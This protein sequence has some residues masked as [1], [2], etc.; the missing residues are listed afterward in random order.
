MPIEY[1][2]ISVLLAGI[3]IGVI[4]T[5]LIVRSRSS[6]LIEQGK[7]DAKAELAL[8]NE[9]LQERNK[10]I[11]NDN[12]LSEENKQKVS[13]LENER[14][15]LGKEL[16]TAIQ[17]NE[18]ILILEKRIKTKEEALEELRH[19][20]S[21]QKAAI[22]ELNTRNEEE[23]S[24]LEEQRTTLLQ[25]K[26][27]LSDQFKTLAQEIFEEKG[28][29]FTEQNQTK[30][31]TILNPFR[32]QLK[33]FKKKVDDVY[34]NEVKERASLKQELENLQKLNKQISQEATNLTKALKGDVK[35]QGNWGEL[36]LERVLEQ[37][38]LRKGVEYETQ[39]G[40]RDGD[41]HLLKP[42]VVIHMPEEKDFVVDSKV[43][44]ID[45]EK[46]SSSTDE[47][48]R[49]EALKAHILSIRK[50]INGLSGKDYS[51]LKGI[52]SLDFVLMFIP[53]EAA[54]MV[55]FQHDEKLFSDAFNKRI[56]VVT[57][58]T[59]LATLKTIENIWRYERQSQN[60]QSIVEKASS[61]YDKLRGFVSDMEK[62]GKQLSTSNRTYDDAMGK[63][64]RGK[65][66]LISQAQQ[67]VDMGVKVKKEISKSITAVSDLSPDDEKE[68]L[69]QAKKNEEPSSTAVVPI[70]DQEN[71]QNI[72]NEKEIIGD[73]KSTNNNHVN[74]T[75]LEDAEELD[76]M[77][78]TGQAK[79]SQSLNNSHEFSNVNIQFEIT[80]P[81]AF[82]KW[83]GFSL[84]SEDRKNFPEQEGA[85]NSFLLDFENYGE[86]TAWLSQGR[87]KISSKHFREIIRRNEFSSDDAFLVE[88]VQPNR[89]YKAIKKVF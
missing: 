75:L 82:I 89:R 40:F 2:L 69:H 48:V 12:Q 6:N 24:K 73:T 23:Q 61:I 27:E 37:S 26:K 68:N 72:A 29:K 10:T 71:I 22:A 60:A 30:L 65:G 45:Y 18:Q 39:S 20:N 67:F 43:S 55:A 3:V 21:S 38:G 52:R 14:N 32:D 42:D 83:G 57:P 78:E 50:H 11:S 62:L 25:A 8:L 9:R 5:L 76:N 35:I 77:N 49:E 13:Q 16:A 81:P 70:L 28:K 41:D 86:T 15:E 53:I 85:D 4:L 54:F 80:A 47:N 46:Y 33:D 36:I 58:T 17:K 44:L 64:T 51:S 87:I 66:N 88:T 84:K 7:S 59:L 1:Q 79:E 19:T 63:L 31:D 74:F 34:V 56:V